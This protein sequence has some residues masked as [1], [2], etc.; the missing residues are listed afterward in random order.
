MTDEVFAAAPRLRVVA[1][2]GV[3]VD[4]VD[5]A[6]AARHGVTVTITPGANANAVAEM[7]VALL[8]ALARPL[9]TGQQRA[10][11]RRMAG[12]QRGR[13]G[14]A[15]PGPGRPGPDRLAG[16]GQGGRA[17]A[18]GC[19][20]TTPTWPAA[21]TA[22]ADAGTVDHG[23]PGHAGGRVDFVSL[24]APLTD[25]TRGMVDRSLPGA[26]EARLGPHQHG[27]GRAGQ[28]GRPAVGARARAR[29]GRPPSTCWPRSRPGP[30]TA[31]CG[32]TTCW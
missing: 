2:Y 1:R 20:P 14:R 27:P 12:P 7:T 10:D 22:G 19:W 11:G 25:Q 28:R 5:L 4:R 26:D 31:S 17:R 18:C 16:G 32:A 6:A 30:T 21:P 23:G 24:H 9:V 8:F 13:A 29:C 15:R 3:G